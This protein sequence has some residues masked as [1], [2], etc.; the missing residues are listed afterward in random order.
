MA[1]PTMIPS[2]YDDSLCYRFQ[3]LFQMG[4]YR[5]GMANDLPRQVT[6]NR[7]LRTCR[8]SLQ[9]QTS[10]NAQ[11]RSLQQDAPGCVVAFDG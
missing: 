5:L 1:A 6:G 4:R 11:S 2:I 10:M 8:A 9:P 3:K 7:Q